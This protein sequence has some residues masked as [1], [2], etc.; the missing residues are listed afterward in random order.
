MKFKDNSLGCTYIA[1]FQMLKPCSSRPG[2]KLVW[3]N[4]GL[5]KVGYAHSDA[6]W[7][8][9]VENWRS[10]HTKFWHRHHIP[11]DTTE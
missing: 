4:V 8:V 10:R 7:N 6:M 11:S 5:A 9:V 2:P 3:A 1:Q